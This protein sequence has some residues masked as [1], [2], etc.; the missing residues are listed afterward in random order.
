MK[1]SLITLLASLFFFNAKSQTVDSIDGSPWYYYLN[2]TVKVKVSGHVGNAGAIMNSNYSISGYTINATINYCSGSLTVLG[3]FTDTFKI[4]PI[5]SGYYKFI[6][7]IN[8]YTSVSSCTQ[9]NNI[10]NS[11]KDSAMIFVDSVA[12]GINNISQSKNIFLFP[13][14]TT[15]ILTIKTNLFCGNSV[16]IVQ[17]MLGTVFKKIPFSQNIN[18]SDLPEGCYF[19]QIVSK[20]KN[21]CKTKFIKQ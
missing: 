7:T 17:D 10:G 5:S 6:V 14:P 21:N 2:D 3:S 1:I 8:D 16:V 13:N 11:N 20:D 15:D 4:Y 9:L 12:S 19:L 18:V